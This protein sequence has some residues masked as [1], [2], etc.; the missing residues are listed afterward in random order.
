MWENSPLGRNRAG[1]DWPTVGPRWS[2]S[3]AHL[4]GLA[5]QEGK[6]EMPEN[7]RMTARIKELFDW[8]LTL[9]QERKAE[10]VGAGH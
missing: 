6:R 2:N 1:A 3:E 10:P 5:P 8:A 4:Q 9:E 7:I